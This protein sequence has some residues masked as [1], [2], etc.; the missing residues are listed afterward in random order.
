LALNARLRRLL[1]GGSPD[2]MAAEAVLDELKAEAVPLDEE[3]VGYSLGRLLR[4]LAEVVTADPDDPRSAAALAEAAALVRRRLPGADL[5]SVQNE[6][7]RAVVDL[8]PER[9]RRAAAGDAAA[10]AALDR[11]A[12]RMAR[13]LAVITD[14]I[15]PDIIVLGGGLS[16]MVH[17]YTDLPRLMAPHVFSDFVRTPVVRNKHGD[18]SGVRGAAWLWPPPD[19]PQTG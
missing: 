11:H 6:V 4:R 9:R 18:S 5:W 15:D 12:D 1:E 2:L 10:R 17:L 7:Y 13:G 3:E 19:A 14:I 16:N 8:L